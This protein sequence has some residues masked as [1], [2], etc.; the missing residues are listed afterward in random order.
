[1]LQDISWENYQVLQVVGYNK[2]WAVYKDNSLHETLARKLEYWFLIIFESSCIVWCIWL[3]HNDVSYNELSASLYTIV[4]WIHN[5]GI[6]VSK[7]FGH[8][9]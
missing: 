5:D 1:M 7:L 2:L 6:F 9:W 8:G 4:I 3:L